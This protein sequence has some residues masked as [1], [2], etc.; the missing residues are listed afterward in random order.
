[1][2]STSATILAGFGGALLGVLASAGVGWWSDGRRHRAER[3]HVRTLLRREVK[4]N[5]EALRHLW[6]MLHAWAE[7]EEPEK[8]PSRM[9]WRLSVAAM[10]PWGRL[11]WESQAPLLASALNDDE[12]ARLYDFYASLQTLTAIHARM[13]EVQPEGITTGSTVL[14][15]YGYEA[16]RLWETFDPLARQLL[17]MPILPEEHTA[18][19]SLT[20]MAARIRDRI[21]S[22]KSRR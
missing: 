1:M 6:E 7:A 14:V 21:R 8:K 3:R 11:M 19:R 10:P 5:Q 16:A 15:V 17:A 18:A 12:F 22:V 9:V 2:D 4:H 13:V 20:P